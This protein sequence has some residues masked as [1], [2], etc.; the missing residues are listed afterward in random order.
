MALPPRALRIEEA[1]TSHPNAPFSAAPAAIDATHRVHLGATD[2]VDES[3]LLAETEELLATLDATA[4][5]ASS[6]ST[7]WLGKESDDDELPDMHYLSPIQVS[8]PPFASV[9]TPAVVDAG[10]KPGTIVPRKKRRS[11]RD[12]RREELL[13]LRRL[14]PQLEKQLDELQITK[15]TNKVRKVDGS[16]ISLLWQ[17]VAERQERLRQHSED[18][19]RRLK[20]MLSGQLRA[21]DQCARLSIDRL[22]LPN[23]AHGHPKRRICAEG[24]EDPGL[25]AVF[26]QLLRRLDV[27]YSQMDAVFQE[28]GLDY[29]LP[30]SRS[31]MQNRTQTASDGRESG[32]AE[33]A[34]VR[35]IPFDLSTVA[36]FTWQSARHWHQKDDPYKYPCVDRPED[37]FA[38]NYRVETSFVPGVERN[39]SVNLKLAMR[40]YCDADRFVFVWIAQS[41]G[42]NA[43]SD[44]FT[45]EMGWLAI[46]RAAPPDYVGESPASFFQMC[47]RVFPMSKHG[48][49]LSPE[50]ATLMS[51][52]V[53]RAFEED[54]IYVYQGME[55]LVLDAS[56]ANRSRSASPTQSHRDAVCSSNLSD[57]KCQAYFA[58]ISDK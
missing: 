6:A 42:E 25:S 35:T 45:N 9:G 51:R 16:T 32:F 1:A 19:N 14:M 50:R 46:S 11:S 15:K 12:I 57:D 30:E 3:S 41:D 48:T 13:Y 58:E 29:S 33:F 18:D 53:L 39:Q 37:T 55:N 21:P 5:A 4:F 26:E 2:D 7:A 54:T 27:A 28:I 49:A 22:H 17:Q 43:F 31:L 34:H 10:S 44:I 56:R 36:T 8:E 52:M 47:M 20:A 38:V 24:E 40:R 23:Y